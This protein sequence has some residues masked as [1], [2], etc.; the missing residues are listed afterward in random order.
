L[1]NDSFSKQYH[2]KVGFI[3]QDSDVQL[4]CSSVWD[5]IAFGPLQMG[6]SEQEVIK[7]VEDVIEMLGLGTMRDRPPYRLSGGEKKKVAI[8]SVL[9]TNPDVFILDE[10]TNGLDPK[11]Q[12][13]LVNLLMQLNMAGKTIITSTHNL[14]LVQEISS[15]II[16]F[17]ESHQIAAD[18]KT[19]EILDNKEL[20]INVNLID[21]YYHKH[22]GQ[23]S[24]YHIHNY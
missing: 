21:E 2:R 3:F 19:N 7:R 9:V 1:E 18:G 13:W 12:R 14:E 4:F 8:A 10:P 5:E 11:S 24:H 17:S 16:V 6:L 20:L 23:H 15:R 22:G